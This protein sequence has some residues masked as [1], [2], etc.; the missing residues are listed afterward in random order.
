MTG[1]RTQAPDLKG[2]LEKLGEPD[3]LRQLCLA[4]V[5]KARNAGDRVRLARES[6]GVPQKAFADLMGISRR[7]LQDMEAQKNVPSGLS[8]A[9]MQGL[10]VSADWVLSGEGEQRLKPLQDKGSPASQDSRLDSV[11]IAVQLLREVLD[12]AELDLTPEKHAEA[13]VILVQLLEMGLPEAEVL[14]F[15]RRTFGR[16]TGGQANGGRAA[17]GG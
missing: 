12:D 14:P 11:K 17:A 2:V 4:S 10:G 13:A 6:L 9:A 3:D 8:L 1:N 7:G 16:T 5:E 15:A